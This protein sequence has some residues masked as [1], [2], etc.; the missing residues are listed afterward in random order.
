MQFDF[1]FIL[2]FLTVSTGIIYFI[3]RVFF[4]KKRL[5]KY[6]TALASMKKKERRKFYKEN[7][8]TAPLIAD[9]SRG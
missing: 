4:Q 3:D 5:E 9:H 7:G 8:L 6:E 1:T 2:L